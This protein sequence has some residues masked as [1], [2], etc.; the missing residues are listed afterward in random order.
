MTDKKPGEL[1]TVKVV[2]ADVLDRMNETRS[3]IAQRAYEIYTSRGGAHGSDQG[4]WFEAE[5]DVLPKLSIEYDVTG[6]DV[7]LSAQV[8]GFNAEDLEVVIGHRRVVICGVHPDLRSST[9]Q[10]DKKVMRIVELPYQVDPAAVRA[11]LQSGALK[12]VLHRLH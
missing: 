8:P 12:V 10:R 4:D 2:E 7:I 9:S 6:G 1:Q 3:L 11:T 5:G